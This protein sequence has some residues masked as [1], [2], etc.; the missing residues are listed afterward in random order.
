MF[1]TE[2]QLDLGRLVS[3]KMGLPVE[4]YNYVIDTHH[5]PHYAVGYLMQKLQPRI[6]MVTHVEYEPELNSELVAGVRAHW[7]GLFV[8]GAPDVK[9][10]NVTKDAIWVRDASLVGLGN[11]RKPQPADAF[12]LAVDPGRG[13]GQVFLPKVKTPREEQQD[14]LY[15]QLEIDPAKYTPKDVQRPLV[16]EMPSAVDMFQGILKAK[17]DEKLD[18]ASDTVDALKQKVLELQGRIKNK[19]RWQVIRHERD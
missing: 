3:L 1:V 14:A 5:T 19:L 16:T 10:V 17:L 2:A 15:R 7:D 18:D 9:V 4:L 12:A 8:V 11:P 6:G 13:L